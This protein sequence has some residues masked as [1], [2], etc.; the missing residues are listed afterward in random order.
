MVYNHSYSSGS[1]YIPPIPEAKTEK[2]E[3]TQQEK[4]ITTEK[5]EVTQEEKEFLKTY[6]EML[7][8]LN[9]YSHNL[10]NY[11]YIKET[12]D[13][14]KNLL[15]NQKDILE[16]FEKWDPAECLSFVLKKTGLLMHPEDSSQRITAIKESPQTLIFAF[17]IAK[18]KNLI[19]DFFRESFYEEYAKCLEIRY[20]HITNWMIKNL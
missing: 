15:L 19:L 2:T 6:E 16:G 11:T 9:K 1:S 7:V 17:N 20:T 18:E 10:K 5:S 4:D 3:V 8:E 13:G 12:L 14:F